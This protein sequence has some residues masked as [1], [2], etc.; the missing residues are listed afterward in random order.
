MSSSKSRK[1]KQKRRYQRT[2]VTITSGSNLRFQNSG[3]RHDFMA[4]RYQIRRCNTSVLPDG[5]VLYGSY[6]RYNI[7]RGHLIKFNGATGAVMAY[8]DFG[9]DTTPAVFAHDGVYS[10]VIKDNHYDEELG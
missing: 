2:Q 8:F 9:W 4:S 3:G 7:A 6:T 5:N 10:I 1:L